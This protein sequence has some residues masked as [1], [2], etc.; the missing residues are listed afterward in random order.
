MPPCKSDAIY[1]VDKTTASEEYSSRSSQVPLHN[2]IL[3][4]RL[5]KRNDIYSKPW[6]DSDSSWHQIARNC[7]HNLLRW[8][9]SLPHLGQYRLLD[10]WVLLAVPFARWPGGW[11]TD[12]QAGSTLDN[13]QLFILRTVTQGILR[14]LL[15]L[16][17]II[18]TRSCIMS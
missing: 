17:T 12:G 6:G 16:L 9:C 1:L 2:S 10:L 3:R 11:Q 15:G 14:D 13:C 8:P 7:K 5:N 18:V 4:R